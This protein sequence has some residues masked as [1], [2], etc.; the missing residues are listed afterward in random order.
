MS[1][2]KNVFLICLVFLLY[3]CSHKVPSGTEIHGYYKVGTPYDINGKRYYPKKDP[4]YQE[5][6]VASWYGPTFHGN[7]TANGAK[8]NTHTFTAAHRTLPLPSMV[9]VTNLNNNKTAVVMVN[10]R[11]PFSKDRIIDVSKK[12]AE[13]LDFIRQGTAKVRVE[14]LKDETKTLLVSMGLPADEVDKNISTPTPS[15]VAA[16]DVPFTPVNTPSATSQ[17]Y[18]QVGTFRMKENAKKIQDTLKD[19]GPDKTVIHPVKQGQT[20]L[21]RVQ[22]GPWRTQADAQAILEKVVDRGHAHA[23]LVMN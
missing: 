4:S 23:L 7:K 1:C 9:R 10:D 13:S 14:F 20:E 22:L 19:L 6:G 3:A 15:V 8:F 17:R 5:E 16:N 21:Y 12:T 2:I 11:G 18:V